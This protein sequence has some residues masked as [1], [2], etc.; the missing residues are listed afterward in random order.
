MPVPRHVGHG[1]STITP[2]PWHWR[3]GEENEKNP[4]FSSITPRP[5]HSEQTFGCVPGLAPLPWHVEHCAS[6]VRCN[7]VVMPCAA[8]AKSS[9][10]LADRSSPRC[11]PA[12]AEAPP[13]RRPRPN[14]CPS[15]SPRPS[16]PT[17]KSKVCPPKPP[18]PALGL[19]PPPNPP[20]IGPRARTSSYSLRLA[21]SPSTS[22][23]ALT[24]LNR[25]SALASPGCVSGWFS[26][27]S[28]RYALV[29]SFGAASFAT[30]RIW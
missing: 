7:V 1:S 28:L 14:I 21:S 3:H 5:P 12:E 26:R 20:P 2:V 10:R 25:S 13:P 8:S 9:V 18:G 11:G 17:L 4:W 6:L 30:P 22:Y 15:T 29:M 27:A 19:N 16:A 24:S 23:A